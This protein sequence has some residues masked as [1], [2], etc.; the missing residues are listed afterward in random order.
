MII[1]QE[2]RKTNVVEYILYMW[3][4][5]DMLR[6]CSFDPEKIDQLLVN[7]FQVDD[8]KRAEIAQW[9][10][11]LAAAMEME[12]VLEKGHLQS[13]VNQVND[14]NSFHLKLVLSQKDS[15]YIRLY[16]LNLEAVNDFISKSGVQ[17]AN[18]IEACLN[19]LYG[20][21]FLKLKKSEISESTKQT[22]AGFA[23]LLGH[24]SARYIQFENDEFEF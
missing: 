21:L 13:L 8:V 24:L 17:F 11:N 9:Y 14:L 23:S 16:Q 5:E 2:K 19:A 12:H 3:Q 1:A 10:K 6:S 20:Y 22:V 4:V 18:D 15:E 7:Q